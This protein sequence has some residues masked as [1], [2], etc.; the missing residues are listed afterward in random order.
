MNYADQGYLYLIRRIM[1]R[2]YDMPDRTGTG[3]RSLFGEQLNLTHIG[4]NFPLLTTKKV[5][6]KGVVEELL[7]FIRGEQNITSLQDKGVRIW[8]EWADNVGNVGP[9][10]GYQ[11]RHWPDYTVGRQEG[12][13]QLAQVI[14]E[15]KNNPWSRRLIVNAWNVPLIPRMG[16]PPCH[17]LFQFQVTPGVAHEEERMRAAV[18]VSPEAADAYQ[19]GGPHPVY[20]NCHMYMRSADVFLGVPFNIASYALLT[21]MVA[22]VTGLKANTLTI[23]FGDVH[24]YH[25]H[26][27]QAETQIERGS[28]QLPK[29]SLNVNVEQIDDFTATDIILHNYN[30]HPPIKADI[31]V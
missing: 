11:W 1:S 27:E 21:M 5:W 9:V 2:G 22:R 6:W 29:V 19:A 4:N 28:R 17:L 31:A 24:L 12:I 15:I 18:L 7:W 10:Y 16:L 8:D 13:D 23:S 3:R 26:F 14:D 20:L 25:N 30:P